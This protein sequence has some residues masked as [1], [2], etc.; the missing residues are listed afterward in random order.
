MVREMQNPAP[1]VANQNCDT[2]WKEGKLVLICF[3]ILV[4][5]PI[6]PW[7][8]VGPKYQWDELWTACPGKQDGRHV[9]TKA[10]GRD[11]RHGHSCHHQNGTTTYVISI[12][13]L[14]QKPK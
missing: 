14:L 3:V 11:E 4:S 8:C 1:P 7:D 5:I 13:K 9:E 2:F 6:L 10:V 12:K